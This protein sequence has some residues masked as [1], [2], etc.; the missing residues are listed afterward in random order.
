MM[1]KKKKLREEID[2][3]ENEVESKSSNIENLKERRSEL[4]AHEG[5][6]M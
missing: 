6:I 3:K 2:C 4:R 1:E 5:I